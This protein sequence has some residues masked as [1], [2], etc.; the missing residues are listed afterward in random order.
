MQ[1]IYGSLQLAYRLREYKLGK[2]NSDYHP[3]SLTKDLRPGSI[4]GSGNV[5]MKHSISAREDRNEATPDQ[6]HGSPLGGAII[7]S[8]V[9]SGCVRGQRGVRALRGCEEKGGREYVLHG[10]GDHRF[11]NEQ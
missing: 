7:P 3:F 11:Q 1:V 5:E 8:H 6:V 2:D 9:L 10:W 4:T